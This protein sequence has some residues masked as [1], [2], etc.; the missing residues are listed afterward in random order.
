M[1]LSRKFAIQFC[2]F[3]FPAQHF[4]AHL[5]NHPGRVTYDNTTRWNF[6]TFF[7]ETQC[8]YNRFITQIYIIHYDSIH[9]YKAISPDDSSMNNCTMTDMGMLP[10]MHRYSREHVD[11]AIFLDI[12]SILKNDLPPVTA[13]RCP[14]SDI[15]ISSNNYISR[16]NRLR[17]YKG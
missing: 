11:D 14:R 4:I 3:A 9:A 13:K 2:A 8:T 5:P 12:T 10:E 15:T 6:F 17:V 1:A 7:N 16:N